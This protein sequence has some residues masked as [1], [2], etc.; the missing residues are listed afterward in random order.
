MQD[1]SLLVSRAQAGDQHAFSELL[2]CHHERVF[3]LI[4]SIVRHESDALELAQDTW[5]KVWQQLPRFRGESRFSTWLH[6]V[7]V[8]AALDH[9]RKRRRWYDRFLPIVAREDFAASEAG[10]GVAEPV[11]P[12]PDAA[13]QLEQQERQEHFERVL[14]ALPPVHRTVLALREVQGLSYDQ[15]AEVMQ[16]RPGTVMSRL[17]HARRLLARKLK[18]LPCD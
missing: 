5:V 10:P 4:F 17:F 2:R 7:A 12:G 1:E 13:R 9:L 11:E 14:A 15:I 6:S 18:D 3:R 16:C 8:R